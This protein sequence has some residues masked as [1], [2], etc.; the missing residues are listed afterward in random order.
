MEERWQLQSAVH[1]WCARSEPRVQFFAEMVGPVSTRERTSIEPMALQVAGGTMRGLQRCISAVRWDEAQM[2]W[3]SPQRVAE[4]R[5]APDGVR[6]F[7]ETGVVNKGQDSVGVARQS[8]GPLGTVAHCPVGGALN[9][10]R[11]HVV[12]SSWSIHAT[13]NAR[14]VASTLVRFVLRIWLS[15]SNCFLF[16]N[17]SSI[18]H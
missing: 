8:C 4:E 9:R 15:R 18:Y 12:V 11:S 16:L 1:D 2:R 14:T 17:T 10:L 5:G 7:D 13:R 3:H 6:R